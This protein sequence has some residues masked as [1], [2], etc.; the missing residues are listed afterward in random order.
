ITGE[1]GQ[2]SFGAVYAVTRR[3]DKQH[4]AM[5]VES[6]NVKKSMLAHEAEVLL[7]LSVVKSAHFVILYDKGSVE[8]R[9]LFL[10]QTLVGINLWDLQ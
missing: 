5:K 9:F 10:V 4:L 7:S 3:S 8:N 2:G 1:L 6:V